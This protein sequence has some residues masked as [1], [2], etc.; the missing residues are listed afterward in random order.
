MEGR[1]WK[2]VIA[3]FESIDLLIIYMSKSKSIDRVG[4][5]QLSSQEVRQERPEAFSVALTPVK[6]QILPG[7]N[8]YQALSPLP[9]PPK[10][11]HSNV[12][13]YGSYS[14]EMIYIET[15]ICK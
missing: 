15:P 7:G 6:R 8:I 9:L 13:S 2:A 5:A 1:V 11:E 3:L 14:K 4:K 12:E 10:M